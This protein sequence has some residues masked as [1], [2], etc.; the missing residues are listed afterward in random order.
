MNNFTKDLEEYLRQKYNC[1]S[2]ILYGSYA[3]GDNT[4]ESDVDIL[5]FR[6]EV[7]ELNDT[8]LFQ[9]KQ[10][11]VWIKNIEMELVPHEFLHIRDGKIISDKNFFGKD[12]LE[13]VKI[14]YDAGPPK[15]EMEQ[16]IFLI[17]WMTK[18][19][20]RSTKKDVEGAY[21]YYWLVKDILEI[22]FELNDKWY[23]GPKK[24][25]KW[26]EDND[27]E[28]FDLYKQILEDGVASK[29]MKVLI[30]K[31]AESAKS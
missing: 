24:S 11:D 20:I 22:Y 21:R 6:D 10:L 30:D 23:E 2:I 7:E 8:S 12:L 25:L 28:V 13:S 17:D 29:N 27:K 4:Q 14:C 18:M 31:L 15:T 19:Y 5:C 9:G 16:K 26:L 3:R 1:T